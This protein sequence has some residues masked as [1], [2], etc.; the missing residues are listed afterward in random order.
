MEFRFVSAPARAMALM[1]LGS[2]VWAE[3]GLRPPRGIE[4]DAQVVGIC[5]CG[6]PPDADVVSGLVTLGLRVRNAS[7]KPIVL[8]RRPEAGSPRIARSV[9][10]G[11]RGAIEFEYNFD[12]FYAS[13]RSFGVSP[14]P[15]EF[16]V[17]APGGILST[18]T[19]ATVLV[20]R[21][22]DGEVPATLLEDQERAIQVPIEWV[23]PFAA[24]SENE[25]VE[26]A[27]RWQRYGVLVA[28]T[29]MTP[30]LTIR[31]PPIETVVACNR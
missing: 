6:E 19:T 7:S 28:G 31:L 1:I 25:I 2:L 26:I 27:E 13:K 3:A 22:T 20:S 24:W 21:R 18:E 4:L 16:A 23:T 12:K 10:D 11:S 15:E 14:A 9:E 29:S 5:Y 30:W 8:W 17:L